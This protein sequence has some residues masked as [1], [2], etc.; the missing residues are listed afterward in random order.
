M[1]I[2]YITNTGAGFADTIEL[3]EQTTV[4]QLFTQKMPTSR[5]EDYLIRVNRQPAGADEVLTEGGRVS[6][7]PLKIEGA[8]G[9]LLP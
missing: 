1:K 5:P 2:F 3:P 8:R 7:T 6:I 9:V 4:G